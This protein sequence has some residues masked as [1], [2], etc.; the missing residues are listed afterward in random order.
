MD[1]DFKDCKAEHEKMD[2]VFNRFILI[3]L[4]IIWGFLSC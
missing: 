2:R 3:V 1:Y 4:L